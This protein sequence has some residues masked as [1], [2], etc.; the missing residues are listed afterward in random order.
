MQELSHLRSTHSKTFDL[1]NGQTRLR[2][3]GA[4]VHFHN[5]S[6]YVEIDNTLSVSSKAGYAYQSGAN[7]HTVYFKADLDSA[8]SIL[9]EYGDVSLSSTPRGIAYYDSALNDYHIL[10]QPQATTFSVEGNKIT[11]SGMYPNC[12][13]GFI[14]NPNGV[15]EFVEVS[16]VA[17]LPEPTSF[18][19]DPATTYLVLINELAHTADTVADESGDLT[20]TRDIGNIAFTKGLKKIFSPDLY[21]WQ[22]NLVRRRYQKL[23]KRLKIVGGKPYLLH[24][25]PYQQIASATS[26]PF[27]IDTSISIDVASNAADGYDQ[28]QA[29]F[30]DDTSLT[31]GGVDDGKGGA[32]MYYG[33]FR[34][35][36]VTVP[37][38]ATINN[39]YITLASLANSATVRMWGEAA[40]SAAAFANNAVPSTRIGTAAVIDFTPGFGTF[41]IKTIIAEIT[42]RTGWASGNALVLVGVGY[43]NGSGIVSVYSYN[44]GNSANYPQLDIDYTS[45]GTQATISPFPCAFRT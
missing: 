24:G 39:A 1:G 18:G 14:I 15:K 30:I 5:G 34:F 13:F 3:F 20:Q 2:S 22:N 35:L 26:F 21:G 9:V 17:N 42:S 32:I 25:I 27:I 4:P 41:Q 29:S 33:G 10:A 19:Y 12:T 43:D 6:D 36:N 16:S 37:N 23:K 45:G 8:D 40:D 38:A 31:M 28:G 7:K 44:N 11:Y